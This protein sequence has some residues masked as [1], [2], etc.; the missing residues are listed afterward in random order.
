MAI[1]LRNCDT[2]QQAIDAKNSF[3]QRLDALT[4]DTTAERQMASDFANGL[5]SALWNSVLFQRRN[6]LYFA[7]DEADNTIGLLRLEI[8]EDRVHIAQVAGVP[9]A[10]AGGELVEL[11]KAAALSLDKHKVDLSTADDRLPAYYESRGF[12][13]V[14]QGATTGEM[15]LDI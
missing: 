6:K 9:G 4:R 12:R 11:S 10:G 14:I 2:Y 3:V 13:M 7:T 5:S 8:K 1:H 15:A